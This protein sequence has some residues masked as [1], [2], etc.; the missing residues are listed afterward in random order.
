MLAFVTAMRLFPLFFLLAHHGGDFVAGYDSL[1]SRS[2]NYTG[3]YADGGSWTSGFAQAKFLVDQMVNITTGQ[4]GKCV[5][6]T[7]EVPRLNLTALCYEDGPVGVRPARRVSQFPAGITTAA[8]WNRKLM[9]ARATALGQEFHD[10]GVSQRR[11]RIPSPI[12]NDLLG[13]VTGGPL[14]RTPYGGRN[15]EGAFPYLNDVAS[16]L[17][18]KYA[19]EQGVLACVKHYIGYEQ[20]TFRNVYNLTEE[21][22]VFPAL[23]QL[24]ISSN[25]D[26]KTVHEVY[27]W[28]FAEAVRAGAG[29]A[30]CS[31]NEV[32][33][34]HSCANDHT[35]NQLLKT[36]LRFQ[37]A[38]VSDWGGTWDTAASA[39]GGLDVSMPGSGTAYGG[40]F[41][42]FYGD[43]LTALIKNGTIPEV[44]LDDMALRALAPIFQY[45]DP[46][47][48]PQPSFDVSDLTI[49]TNNVR[50][51]HHIIIRE[52]A[53]SSMS[54]LAVIGEDASASPYGATSCGARGDGGTG[55]LIE[56][57]RTMSMGGGSGWAYP[58]YTIDPLAAINAYVRQD[59]PDIN[60]HLEN[61]DLD[62]AA[63]Q[64][65]SRSETALVFINAYAKEGGDRHNLTAVMHIPGPV[66]VENWIDH[67]NVT[68]VVI[69][70]LPGQE[71][72]NSLVPVL[73][74]ERSPSGKLPYTV[75]RNESDWPPNGIVF[76][77]VFAPQSN[78]S[79]KILV[80][81]K[82]FDA[83]N[84]TPR[85]EF[86]FGM[87]YTTFS[88]GDLSIAKTFSADN[89]SIQ[90][91]AEP[92]VRLPSD[93]GSSMYDVLYTATLEVMN[94][95]W[96]NG[97]EVAQ[98][99]TWA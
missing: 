45:Q 25:I 44:R 90:P 62:A 46:N 39:V 43:E 65:S 81:Y 57:N 86:G 87:S 93:A 9:A 67:E 61:W 19:Q 88:F 30:I 4:T 63:L 11:S 26:D 56:N 12:S 49:P 10:K 38:V 60:Q 42:H 96:V 20:E 94:T 95:G 51:D 80:D 64:A 14:G 34:T 48:Y 68:A 79:E 33:Q 97:A 37:G 16:Y 89:T 98:L 27:L 83:K 70:H 92:F 69:A 59:G 74:G 2:L 54:T 53:P 73:W 17:S 76:D 47:T 24:P 5:G 85:W 52:I 99:Y 71:S 82:W 23:Q 29:A 58:P 66:L 40:L 13:P 21:Y 77:P 18:V 84:I 28:P 78:F 32:N 22:S 8:T 55:C 3:P 31:Y 15:W 36:E 35:L 6:A 50:R 91:T 72:G 75:A 1:H 7:G 41:G